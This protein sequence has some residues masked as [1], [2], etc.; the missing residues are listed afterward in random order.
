MPPPAQRCSRTAHPLRAPTT[1]WKSSPACRP[2]IAARQPRTRL[3]HAAACVGAFDVSESLFTH[4]VD[5]LRSEARLHTL[6]T[7]LVL[8]SWSALRL[9]HWSTAVSAAEEGGRLC[10]ETD[11]P[12]WHAC[13]LAAHATVTARRGEFI[14]PSDLIEVAERI[15]SRTTSPRPTPSSSSRARRWHQGKASTSVP[16]PVSRVCTTRATQRATPFTD[17]GVAREP[18]RGRGH[19][20]PSRRRGARILATLRPDVRAT[21]SPAGRMN[22]TLRPAGARPRERN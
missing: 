4:A 13:A 12:F 14:R 21:H 20:R 22:L 1:S 3:G 5:A 18:R 9:G 8:L 6:G 2:S 11:Q 16:S 10:G 19:V 7:T 17:Y 15:A